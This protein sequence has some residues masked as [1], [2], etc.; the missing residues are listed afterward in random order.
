M[1]TYSIFMGFLLFTVFFFILFFIIRSLCCML[2][3]MLEMSL[4]MSTRIA[5][6]H[7]NVVISVT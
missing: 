3:F 6:L 5:I 4:P 1:C 7:Y 2:I